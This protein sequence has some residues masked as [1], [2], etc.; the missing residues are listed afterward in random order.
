MKNRLVQMVI[1]WFVVG[2]M[3]LIFA[4]S[5]MAE[6]QDFPRKRLAKEAGAGALARY[7]SCLLPQMTP[8]VVKSSVSDRPALP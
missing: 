3:V 4:H 7:G 5:S 6:T 2:I 1:C 8:L